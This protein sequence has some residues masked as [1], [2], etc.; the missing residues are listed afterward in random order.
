[1]AFV[2]L[3]GTVYASFLFMYIILLFMLTCRTLFVYN[4]LGGDLKGPLYWDVSEKPMMEMFDLFSAD[5]LTPL[6]R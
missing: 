4:P 6:E 1:V 5:T 2:E 3:L